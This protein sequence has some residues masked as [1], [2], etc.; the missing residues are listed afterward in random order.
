MEPLSSCCCSA[1]SF[2]LDVF[3]KPP[4]FSIDRRASLRI[5][6]RAS[7]LDMIDS[8]LFIAAESSELTCRTLSFKVL[9]ISFEPSDPFE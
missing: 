1:K 2:S 7:S 4:L 9:I 5:E 8:S 3:P 6:M